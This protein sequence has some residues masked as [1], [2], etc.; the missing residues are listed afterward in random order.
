MRSPFPTLLPLALLLPVLCRCASGQAP[1][2]APEPGDAGPDAPADLAVRGHIDG[3]AGDAFMLD[4]PPD[5]AAPPPWEMAD[6]GAVQVPGRSNWRAGIFFV[7]GSGRE[8]GGTE[9][10][11]HFLF[12]TISGDGEIV[13]HLSEIEAAGPEGRAGLMIRGSREA[14]APFAAFLVS[15][16]GRALFQ[17]RATAG[18]PAESREAIGSAGMWVKL[19]RDGDAIRAAVSANRQ[20][21]TEVGQVELALPPRTLLG[22]AVT[23]QGAEGRAMGV[24]HSARV[25]TVPP[26]WIDSDVGD[27]AIPGSARVSDD[28]VVLT[29]SGSDIAGPSDQLTY[30]HQ[31]FAGDGEI[32]A[33]VARFSFPDPNAKVGLMFRAGPAAS[34]AHLSLLLTPQGNLVLR[35]A[36]AGAVGQAVGGLFRQLPLV[37]MR[38]SRIGPELL[39]YVSPDGVTW[40]LIHRENLAMPPPPMAPLPPLTSVGLALTSRNNT[41]VAVARLDN[42]V[43]KSY[44]PYPADAGAGADASADAGTP[45]DGP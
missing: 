18:A 9:D 33:R 22:L 31:P 14:G 37:W 28:Q 43:V 39:S 15:R 24:F 38:M 13:A 17:M 42:V 29:G 3:A 12:Q 32:T 8:I 4:G 35:R 36:S 40:L 30:L 19:A 16:D 44:P 20:D 41:Q 27:V 11:F 34:A 7:R 5:P 45:A 1:D 26:P 2:P 23:A 25:T 21:W 10:G 6:V